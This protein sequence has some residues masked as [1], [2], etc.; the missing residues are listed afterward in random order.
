MPTVYLARDTNHGRLVAIKTLRPRVA[1]A[2]GIE[3]L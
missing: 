1:S 2:L 3:R